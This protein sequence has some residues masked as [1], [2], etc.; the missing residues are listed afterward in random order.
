M[1]LLPS[2]IYKDQ[3]QL[4]SQTS[5]TMIKIHL[6]NIWNYDIYNTTIFVIMM[7]ADIK[8]K[9]NQILSM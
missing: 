9:Q 1:G 7:N 3:E 5:L 4:L 2:H 6:T 8:I